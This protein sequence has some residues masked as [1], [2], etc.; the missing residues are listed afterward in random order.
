VLTTNTTGTTI[1]NTFARPAEMLAKSTKSKAA[2]AVDTRIRKAVTTYTFS[3]FPTGS[4]LI[5]EFG[6]ASAC[7]Q[8]PPFC[9]NDTKM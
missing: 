9:T 7:P 4:P 6:R 8:E 3:N 2:T 5:N 1:K